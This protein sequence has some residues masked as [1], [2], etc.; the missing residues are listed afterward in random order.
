MCGGLGGRGGTSKV[1]RQKI[2]VRSLDDLNTLPGARMS[3][4]S[5]L[6]PKG[7]GRMSL[8]KGKGVRCVNPANPG[9]S[10]LIEHG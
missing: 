2:T 10:I 1:R 6:I 9:E 7:W 4:V 5:R 3:E 8:K